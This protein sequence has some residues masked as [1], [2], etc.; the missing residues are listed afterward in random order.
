MVYWPVDNGLT[1]CS[2]ARKEKDWII[3]AKEV[4]RGGMWMDI[5]EWTQSVKTFVSH[6]NIYQK[7]SVL[8]GALSNQINKLSWPVEVSQALSSDTLHQHDRHV[9][10]WNSFSGRA[11]S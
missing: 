3:G 6:I 2:G 11:G 9:N 5:W 7:A 10:S 1:I 8:E 4:W